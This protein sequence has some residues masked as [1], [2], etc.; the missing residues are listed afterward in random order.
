MSWKVLK[1]L[2]QQSGENQLCVFSPQA[3]S[4]TLLISSTVNAKNFNEQPSNYWPANTFDLKVQYVTIGHLFVMI[5]T[6]CAVVCASLCVSCVLRWALQRLG[7]VSQ[8][9]WSSR[10]SHTCSSSDHQHRLKYSGRL[11]THCQNVLCLPCSCFY[12]WL[13]A[14]MKL[15]LFFPHLQALRQLHSHLHHLHESYCGFSESHS[16]VPPPELPPAPSWAA[17]PE[18]EFPPL[19]TTW[20]A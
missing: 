9:D 6:V 15:C 19:P 17:V 5:W 8:H 14:L 16:P 2:S 4:L 7:V 3:T 10:L 18:P 11:S 1:H 12:P 13:F 20:A